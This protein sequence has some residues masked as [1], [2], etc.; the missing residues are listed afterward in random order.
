MHTRKPRRRGPSPSRAMS[1]VSDA[2]PRPAY[3]RGTPLTDAVTLTDDAGTCWLVYVEPAPSDPPLRRSAAVL[4]GRRLR[5][6]SL[7]RSLVVAPIPAGSPFLS[8]ERLQ[9]LLAEARPVPAPA[10]PA[11]SGL[12]PARAL[13]SVDW[14]GS[15][16]A[17]AGAVREI[18]GRQWRATAGV[19]RVCARG[20]VQVVA[21]AV[22]LMVVLWEAML[23]RPRARI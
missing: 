11:V 20:L 3:P 15:V 22:L 12:I 21:P 1:V 14:A 2:P 18:A 19:R 16:A 13:R 17:A 5:F 4:P 6:D 7:E 10:P 8:D 23:V 9:R